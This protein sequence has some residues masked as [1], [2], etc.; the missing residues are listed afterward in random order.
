MIAAPAFVSKASSP[1]PKRL[2]DCPLAGFLEAEWVGWLVR[3]CGY[4]IEADGGMFM[5]AFN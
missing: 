2:R 4:D 3:F 5:Q 1:Q